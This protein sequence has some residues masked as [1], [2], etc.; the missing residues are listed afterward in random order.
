VAF[1]E[2]DVDKSPKLAGRILGGTNVPIPQM[3][4]WWHDGK[5]SMVGRLIGYAPPEKVG[6]FIHARL[7]RR[8][9]PNR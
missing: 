9:S 8:P 1:C 6:E 5:K 7:S 4:I 2:V 3:I